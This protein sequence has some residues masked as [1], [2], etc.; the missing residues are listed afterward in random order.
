MRIVE[1]IKEGRA[2]KWYIVDTG[3]RYHKEEIVELINEGKV[4]NAKIQIY[5]GKPIVRIKDHI[6]KHTEH[7]EEVKE[8]KVTVEKADE[9]VKGSVSNV[10][11]ID[12]AVEEKKELGNGWYS[13]L[14]SN[15]EVLDFNEDTNKAEGTDIKDGEEDMKIVSVLKEFNQESV[16]ELIQK[17]KEYFS[18][19]ERD[20]GVTVEFGNFKWSEHEIK[21]SIQISLGSEEEVLK[22]RWKRA[23]KSMLGFRYN[24]QDSDFGKEVDTGT[25]MAKIIGLN[26]SAPKFPVLAVINGKKVR[27][28]EELL[29]MMR[30]QESM[31]K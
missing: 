3:E 28:T 16:E 14:N 5:Q 13:Q 29:S 27:Y 24:L 9:E 31:A 4:E 30:R 2:V 10:E 12:E 20:N 22:R 15:N 17:L 23:V 25:G 21:S 19:F 7:K 6:E 8:S 1:A 18:A 26:L 11:K